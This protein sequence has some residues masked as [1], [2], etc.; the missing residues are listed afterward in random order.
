MLKVSIIIP[1]YNTEK[2]IVRCLDSIVEQE[3]ENVSIECVLVDDCSSDNSM[4]LIQSFLNS[5]NGN[6]QFV[7]KKQAVNQGPAS[8]RNVG[9][10][11]STG[12]YILFVDSDD[13]LYPESVQYMIDEMKKYGSVDV[14]I[15]NL[16]HEEENNNHFPTLKENLYYPDNASIVE[17]AFEDRLGFYSTNKLVRRRLLE[18]NHISFV[19]GLLY[20]DIP[21][22]VAVYLV[23]STLLALP[24][25]TYI[26]K[27]NESS[28]MHT[29]G[30]KADKT[31]K[32][33]SYTVNYIL[34]EVT[35]STESRCCVF[36]LRLMMRAIDLKM[37]YSCS[38]EAT[39]ELWKCRKRLHSVALKGHHYLLYIA[40]F[41]M[42]SPFYYLQYLSLFRH[43]YYRISRILYKIGT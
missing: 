20:E 40:F 12:D 9:F 42:Y 28:I 2:Y 29:M 6:I 33:L 25:N 3:C 30:S 24:K 10:D 5:Y 36:S 22:A 34:D 21:W 43:N 17:T 16:F 14:I 4:S 23:A 37:R 11:V 18:E 7:V 35:K 15:G 27:Y 13:C 32:S 26:Y 41:L 38:E 39:V 19:S 1:V 31:V 8:A